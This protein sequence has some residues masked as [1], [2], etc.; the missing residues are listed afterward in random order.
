MTNQTET[1][2]ITE[3]EGVKI[4]EYFRSNLDRAKAYA[5]G[6]LK[7]KDPQKLLA[8]EDLRLVA[9]RMPLEPIS[10][11]RPETLEENAYWLGNLK[12]KG[13]DY[14]KRARDRELSC[15]SGE[16]EATHQGLDCLV[17]MERME[18]NPSFIPKWAWP[19]VSDEA[20]S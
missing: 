6:Y 1:Q 18:R 9:S 20:N 7:E 16:L 4:P 17:M 3:I 11:T 5:A 13:P 2:G 15:V 12:A 14:Q 8:I 19:G 10:E